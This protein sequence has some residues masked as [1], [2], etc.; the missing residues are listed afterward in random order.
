M[1]HQRKR[2]LFL[3]EGI[4]MT[5]FVRPAALAETLDPSEWE[6]FF[7]TPKRFHSLLSGFKHNVGDLQTIEPRRF[8]DALAN[9]ARLYSAEVLH[10]YVSDDLEI[11][12]EVQ[13]D[14][15]IGDL[16]LSL[17]ISA[18]VAHVSFA[19]IFNAHWSPFRRQPPVIPASPLTRWVSPRLLQPLVPAFRPIIYAFHAKPFNDVRRSFGLAPLSRDLRAIYASGDLTLYPDVPEFVPLLSMPPSHHF[20]GP[21]VRSSAIPKPSWWQEAMNNPLPKI[22]VSMG[23]SGPVDAIPS[24]LEAASK[25]SA[26]VILATSG[27]A[28]GPIRANV[29]TADLLPY[30]ETAAQCA[31]GVSQGGMGGLYP[32]LAAGTPMLAVPNNVDNLLATALLE[33][34]GAGLGL[35][36]EKASAGNLY[37]ILKRLLHEPSFKRRATEW[38]VVV[39]RC[40][41]TKL[42][43]QILKTWFSR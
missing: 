13:P 31:V 37:R 9:G 5:H 29:F 24:V 34:S 25:L 15:V 2:I 41:T 20:I 3:A 38:A 8:L 7:R 33:E 1:L 11:I 23:S 28:I 18:P 32:T 19:S 36:A 10:Q 12:K 42:F 21:C 39:R 26:Q 35:R 14:L 22:F 16:R 43:P 6:V 30:E 4:T 27:R 17:C 40:D